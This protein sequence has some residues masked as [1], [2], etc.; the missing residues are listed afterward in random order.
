MDDF[1]DDNGNLVFK[2]SQGGGTEN[3]YVYFSVERKPQR[4]W[5]HSVPAEKNIELFQTRG[6]RND[7]R[8]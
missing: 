6:Y 8:V 3:N 5:E 7:K 2:P 4:R 1:F